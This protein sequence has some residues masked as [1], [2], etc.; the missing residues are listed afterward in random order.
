MS[1]VKRNKSTYKRATEWSQ[2][3][4]FN[5]NQLNYH[6]EF[7]SYYTLPSLSNIIYSKFK[8]NKIYP[9]LHFQTL[10]SSFTIKTPYI[11][12]KNPRTLSTNPTR[13]IHRHEEEEREY[14]S[15]RK[16]KED[17]PR[18]Q[19]LPRKEENAVSFFF[20]KVAQSCSPS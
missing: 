2:I 11:C 3:S 15:S 8:N 4:A 16:P 5:I 14:F 1:R 10:I 7:C 20:F 9:Y 18:K 12:V 13:I 17:S 19:A 6:I